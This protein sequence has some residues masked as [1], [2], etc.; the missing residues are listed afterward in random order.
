MTLVILIGGVDGQQIG[1]NGEVVLGAHEA[2]TQLRD[3]QQPEELSGNKYR[4][5]YFFQSR[6][7]IL[8]T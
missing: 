1:E 4:Q 8:P 6:Q 7:G 5:G 2:P 3:I